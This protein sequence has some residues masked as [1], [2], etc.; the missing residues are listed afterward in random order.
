MRKMPYIS[1]VTVNSPLIGILV[2]RTCTVSPNPRQLNVHETD[3]TLAPDNPFTPPPT[4]MTSVRK[5]NT[6]PV[7]YAQLVAAEALG[8]SGNARVM[9]LY[10]DSNAYHRAGYAST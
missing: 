3:M 5:W 4:N 10:I 9:D 6:G 1:L 8:K 7:F 2:A